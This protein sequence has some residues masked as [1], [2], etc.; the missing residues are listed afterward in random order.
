MLDL[1]GAAGPADVAV[2]GTE[3]QVEQQLRAY[4]SLGAS[5]ALVLPYP[6]GEDADASLARTRAL[7]TSLVGR[8]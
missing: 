6:V 7:L 2:C 1:E 5:D 8:I 3:A 4:A